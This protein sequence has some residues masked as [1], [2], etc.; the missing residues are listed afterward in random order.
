MALRTHDGRFGFYLPYS[1]PFV[2]AVEAI[3]RILYGRIHAKL[4]LLRV[5]A[6]KGPEPL[7]RER[8][9]PRPA[10]CLA[11]RHA[12]SAWGR[13]KAARAKGFARKDSS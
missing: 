4:H 7:A 2:G 3:G 5:V 8:V 1:R 9:G 6:E 10:L 12:S 11:A 13:S